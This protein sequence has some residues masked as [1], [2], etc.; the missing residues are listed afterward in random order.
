VVAVTLGAQVIEKHVCLSRSIPS[1]DSAFSMEIEEYKNLVRDLKD[2]LLIKGEATYV[3]T[4]KEEESLVIRRSLF[5]VREIKEG[6]AF[7]GEN[8]RSIR[9]GYGIKP[10]YYETLLGK[11][12][13]KAYEFGDPIDRIEIE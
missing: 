9:P 4:E 11:K 5:A 10:K 2:A 12:A 7:T 6:E 8:V 1:A 3:R 13:R